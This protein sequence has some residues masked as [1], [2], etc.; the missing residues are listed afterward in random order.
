MT[1][2]PLKKTIF[3]MIGIIG[4]ITAS[5]NLQAA[6]FDCVKAS[7]LIEKIICSNSTASSLDEQ[8]NTIYKT[9]LEKS[10]DKESLKKQQR[11]WLKTSRNSCQSADCV[12]AAYSERISHFQHLSQSK[13]IGASVQVVLESSENKVSEIGLTSNPGICTDSDICNK[14]VIAELTKLMENK[15]S[16]KGDRNV[17]MDFLRNPFGYYTYKKEKNFKNKVIGSGDWSQHIT[18][19]YLSVDIDNDG[20][21][22]P[23]IEIKVHSGAGLGCDQEYFQVPNREFN[24]ISESPL[25]K[26]LLSNSCRY[27]S[28]PF[29]FNGKNYIENRAARKD[30]GELGFSKSIVV[31]GLFIELLS[32][33]YLIEDGRL[34]T[35]CSY[36]Y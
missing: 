7:T 15:I 18:S 5:G 31:N 4:A 3:Q 26:I 20:K 10:L 24:E 25:N 22:E 8:L 14:E 13:S 32:D 33:V 23:L 16:I 34:N 17:C 2:A 29:L 30:V 21:N 35:V 6:S 28:R 36:T 12:I 19:G 11:L 9:V 1:N 27:Y